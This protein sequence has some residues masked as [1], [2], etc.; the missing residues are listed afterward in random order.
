VPAQD[1]SLSRSETWA[2]VVCQPL[3]Q[4]SN[5]A[6]LPSLGAMRADLDLSYAELGWVVAAFGVTR[7]VVDLP[8]GNLASRWNPR[9]VLIA[10]LTLSALGSFAGVLA[11]TGWQ[12][13]VVRL[14][15]GIG[16]AVAQAM[17]LAWIVG[18][19]GTAARGRALS[20]SEAFFSSAGLVIPVL[21]GLLAAPLG[22][23]V[24][25]VMG[26]V[27][28][29][30]GALA[31]VWCT[32]SSSA[33]RAVGLTRINGS[34]ERDQRAGWFDLRA[35]GKVLLAA[36]LATFGVFF[37]RNG[38]LN[39]VVPV[40]GS[41]RFGMSPF[42]IGALFSAINAVGIG[43]VLVGGRCADRFG[44]Y[45]VLV[46]ALALLSFSQGLLLAVHDSVSYILVGLV[47]GVA[48]F[49]NPIPTIVMGD[50]LTPRLRARGIAVYR[51]VCDV[52][53]L[54]APATMGLSIQSAG[55]GAAETLNFLVSAIVLLGVYVLYVV[56][57]SN[58]A[59]LATSAT[60][61]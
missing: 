16:S 39:S 51:A 48:C 26:A 52:A 43:A 55:F 19:S 56:S 35:G 3:A 53:I 47:Q 17:L 34:R 37:C 7:L 21:G 22:W 54:S 4:L 33:A 32:R 25:F 59:R 44:R 14:L 9:S 30:S 36:Y 12:I 29:L 42:E 15:I 38:M 28:A 45:R 31:I 13:A 23:R 18:G 2:L 41:E 50:A 6:L 8:A 27:A 20:Y 61:S 60:D 57:R 5:Q 46:P 58:V 11:T 10:A 1:A 24:A 49:V 40:L